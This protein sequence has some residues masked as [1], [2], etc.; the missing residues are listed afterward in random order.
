MTWHLQQAFRAYGQTIRHADGLQSIV[1][2]SIIKS[3]FNKVEPPLN[4]TKITCWNGIARLPPTADFPDQAGFRYVGK[5]I[6]T[7]IGRL[8]DKTEDLKLGLTKGINML[9]KVTNMAKNPHFKSPQILKSTLSVLSQKSISF[10]KYCLTT[11]GIC[12]TPYAHLLICR[13]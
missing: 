7:A 1:R 3:K 6:F 13:Y 4:F 10:V 9:P 8:T 2:S 11:Y 12:S 5:G